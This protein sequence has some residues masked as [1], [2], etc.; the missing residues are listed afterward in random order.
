MEKSLSRKRRSP[1][2]RHTWPRA[3][4]DKLE[5]ILESPQILPQSK[6]LISPIRTSLA[7]DTTVQWKAEGCS[8]IDSP[9]GTHVDTNTQMIWWSHHLEESQQDR[10][11]LSQ[12]IKHLEAVCKTQSQTNTALLQDVKSWRNNYKGVEAE[13]IEAAQE[14]EEAKAYVRSIETANANLRYALAQ[15]KEE[16]ERA[17]RSHWTNRLIRWLQSC[18][19]A[20][21]NVKSSRRKQR[22]HRENCQNSE[23]GRLKGLDS[24]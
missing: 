9:V 15:A 21:Q 22:D 24:F 19:P 23:A 17:R 20:Q 14:I 6:F 1:W 8:K 18:I 3:Q 4:V 2:K 5:T 7:N 13:L 10:Q 11:R 12:K 16:Q